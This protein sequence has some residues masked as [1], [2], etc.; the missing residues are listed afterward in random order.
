MKAVVRVVRERQSA[1][2]TKR[3]QHKSTRVAKVCTRY[4]LTLTL[5]AR[6]HWPLYNII[7]LLM[8]NGALESVKIPESLAADAPLHFF[9]SHPHLR[10]LRSKALLCVTSRL[11]FDFFEL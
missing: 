3:A 9:T 7:G 10:A 2:T 1:G 6:L 8:V 5:R 11:S 4:S